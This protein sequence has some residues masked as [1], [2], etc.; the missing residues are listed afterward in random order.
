MELETHTQF[1][2]RKTLKGEACTILSG[3]PCKEETIWN[4]QV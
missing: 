1:F 2:F 4:T 3:Q